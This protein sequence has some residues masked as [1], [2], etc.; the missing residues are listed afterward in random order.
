MSLAKVLFPKGI[1]RLYTSAA[2]TN[3][4]ELDGKAS[5][6]GRSTSDV[7]RGLLLLRLSS[8]ESFVQNTENLYKITERVLGR[9]ISEK[10]LEKTFY[11]QFVAGESDK[12]LE[13]ASARLLKNGNVKLMLCP[14]MEDL[15]GINKNFDVIAEENTKKFTQHLQM[16]KALNDKQSGQ[17]S[18]VQY[19]LSAAFPVENF[20]KFSSII[21]QRGEG[22]MRAVEALANAL[23][24]KNA[25]YLDEFKLDKETRKSFELGL[26]ISNVIFENAKSAGIP[27][28]IDAEL[29]SS[30]AAMYAL[31]MALSALYNRPS[32]PQPL[33][34]GTYQCYFRDT[35]RNLNESLDICEKLGAICVAKLVRGAYMTQERRIAAA[36]GV[37]DP[38]WSTY[39]ETSISYNGAVEMLLRCIAGGRQKVSLLVASHNKDSIMKTVKLMKELGINKNDPSVKF[40]QIYGMCDHISF[41]L[42]NAGYTVYKSVPWGSVGEWVPY[43]ARRASENHTA[44]RTARNEVPLYKQELKRRIFGK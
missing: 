34:F 21:E 22:W 35:M 14:P 33:V 27:I 41:G 31:T 11:A 12:A 19:K 17:H 2:I 7:A 24:S 8:F 30:H 16:A 6:I 29:R 38:I 4:D 40:G 9:R 39:D 25:G 43:L 20:D 26:S 15:E 13:T 1:R 3:G 5:F 28:L 10:L 23:P 36:N 18:V 37:P 42:G 44:F 32:D